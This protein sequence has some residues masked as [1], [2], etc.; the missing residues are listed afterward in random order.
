MKKVCDCQS[1]SESQ[2]NTLYYSSNSPGSTDTQEQQATDSLHSKKSE[3]IG[4]IL[5]DVN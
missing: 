2:T 5:A 4:Y 1:G 3:Y